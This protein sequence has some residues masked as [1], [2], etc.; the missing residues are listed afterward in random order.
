M[1]DV[2]L[3]CSICKKLIEKGI[4]YSPVPLGGCDTCKKD[5]SYRVKLKSAFMSILYDEEEICI[6]SMNL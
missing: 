3:K 6:Q 5:P 4:K 1:K 2:G